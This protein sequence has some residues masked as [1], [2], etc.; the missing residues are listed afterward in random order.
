MGTDQIDPVAGMLARAFDDDPIWSNLWP[1]AGRRAAQLQRMFAALARTSMAAGG[2]ATTL[3]GHRGA[4]LWLPPGRGM[5][6]RAVV[7]SRFAMPRM[8]LRMSR[9][10][11]RSL[12]AMVTLLDTRHAALVPEPHWYLWVVGVEPTLHGQGLGTLLVRD[13]LARAD[14]DGTPVYLETETTSNVDYYQGLGF[15]VVEE[16]VAPGVG[17]P[18]WLMV[19]RPS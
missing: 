5:R 1:D 11:A 9:G 14:G 19:R 15:T 10:E 3:N 13:G 7:R 17:V 16:L 18:L 6:A 2:H 4:A 12:M 8:V